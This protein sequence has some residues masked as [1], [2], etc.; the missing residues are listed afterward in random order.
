MKDMNSICL[1]KNYSTTRLLTKVNI[2][3]IKNREDKGGLRTQGYLKKSFDDKPLVSI[4]TVVYNGEVFLEKTIQSVINQS[5]SN[6]EYI[7]IDGGSTDE[8]V[9][10]IKKY[11]DRIDYWVSEIDSGIYDAMNKGIDLA[12]GDWINFMNAGDSFVGCNVL[13]NLNYFLSDINYDIIY[14]DVNI[15]DTNNS[16]N[17]YH[18]IS[19]IIDKSFLMEGTICHQSIFFRKILFDMYEKH[20]LSYKIVGDFERLVC[21]F[22]KGVK[23]K[24]SNMVICNYLNDGFSV[25]N[26]YKGNIE[27]LLVLKKSKWSSVKII[28][29]HWIFIVYGWLHQQKIRLTKYTGR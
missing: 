1:D 5:Y 19:H 20:D 23:F 22:K 25:K 26:Y 21:F 8:T 13:L 2:N 3:I 15:I 6:I 10:I 9:D 27:R 24:H 28:I 17:L 29:I 12:S 7:I 14:G 4:V 18:R 16:K 11:E